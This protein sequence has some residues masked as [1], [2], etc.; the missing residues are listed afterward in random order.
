MHGLS[1]TKVTHVCSRDLSVIDTRDGTCIAMARCQKASQPLNDTSCW[2]HLR[3]VRV[4]EVS[5]QC[6]CL[7]CFSQL[8]FPEGHP[9]LG[10]CHISTPLFRDFWPS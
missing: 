10:L 2:T 5:I 4:E 1:C 6:K 7:A 9:H 3:S 8:R